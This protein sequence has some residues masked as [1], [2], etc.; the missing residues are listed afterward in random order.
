M[1]LLSVTN[2]WVR[3]YDFRIETHKVKSRELKYYPLKGR[4][5]LFIIACECRKWEKEKKK[6]PNISDSFSWSIGQLLWGES[7]MKHGVSCCLAP[8][9]E[10]CFT[11]WSHSLL[12]PNTKR[13][14][15]SEHIKIRYVHIIQ[16]SLKTTDSYHTIGES[17]SVQQSIVLW[18]RVQ[19]HIVW[20][21][22]CKIKSF[23]EAII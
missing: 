5:Q 12:V 15:C 3:A 18:N 1:G 14:M 17:D 4:I 19:N 13:S 10:P 6:S 23:P 7:L 22:K 21:E 16:L 11:L 9:H 20:K 8:Q 2:A